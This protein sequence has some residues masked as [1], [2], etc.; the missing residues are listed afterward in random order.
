MDVRKNITTD[1][2]D[3][4]HEKYRQ[5]GGKII[6]SI[7]QHQEVHLLSHKMHGTNIF[8]VLVIY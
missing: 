3:V 7:Q 8:A 2:I 4:F 1:H 5:K 6:A